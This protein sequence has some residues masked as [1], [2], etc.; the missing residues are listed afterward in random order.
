MTNASSYHVEYDGYYRMYWHDSEENALK[1]WFENFKVDKN[2]SF[3][4]DYEM[5]VVY[6]RPASARRIKL[7]Q[8][9]WIEDEGRGTSREVQMDHTAPPAPMLTFAAKRIWQPPPPK[10]PE[11]LRREAEYERMYRLGYEPRMRRIPVRSMQMPNFFSANPYDIAPDL[12]LSYREEIEW[13][14]RRRMTDLLDAMAYA[15][16][17]VMPTPRAPTHRRNV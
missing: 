2:A 4:N 16:T 11:E 5:L 13:V 14:P 17:A 6:E 9:C 15:R 3:A 8:I 1:R 7:K 10:S 12:T